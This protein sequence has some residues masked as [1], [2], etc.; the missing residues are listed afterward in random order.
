MRPRGKSGQKR[1]KAA[2]RR[3][4][5]RVLLPL[6]LGL[7][8]ATLAGWL[9]VHRFPWAGPL[10]ADSLRAVVGVD[11]VTKLE[12]F[13]YGIEDR[14]NRFA[15]SSEKPKAYWQVP[16]GEAEA[17]PKPSASAD[18][19]PPLPP[20]RPKDV[21]PVHESWSAPGDGIWVAVQDPRHPDDDP[22]LRKTLLHP[23]KYRSWAELFV[24]AVD[25][26]RVDVHL[27]A[28]RYEPKTF[29][30]DAKDYERPA[31]IPESA[32][33]RL[34]AAFNGSFKTEHGYYGMLIDGVTLVKPRKRACTVALYRNGQLRIGMWPK[35]ESQQA[36]L[37]WYRQAPSCMV[38]DG[39]MHPGL[40]DPNARSWGA[41][42]DG[43]TVIRRSAVGLNRARDVLYVSISN[44]TTAR[45]IAQ[46]MEHA[47]ATDVAQ[48]DVNWSYP[49]FVLFHPRED[50]GQ[51]VAVALAEGFEFSED[52][53]VRKRSH[54]DFFYLTR[55]TEPQ[56]TAK[57]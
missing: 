11:A 22:R 27:V 33:P 20:F 13:V 47:G 37:V 53:Y 23:D 32:Y 15:R 18:G 12:D 48:L 57:N 25:L 39:K 56:K 17:S 7:V 45:A 46:G 16:S 41:T 40:L 2:P 19:P 36:D 6:A 42:L 52:E 14:W 4:L 43:E 51:L 31:R 5:R 24:V 29:E 26:R 8:A 3:R 1:K 35:L 38:E 55:K 21:G 30:P 34:L 10:V 28:G 44:H 50:D 9:A 49:K 54:R